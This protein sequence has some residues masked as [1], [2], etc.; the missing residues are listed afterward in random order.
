MN[1]SPSF[2]W[3]VVRVVNKSA[4]PSIDRLDREW[5]NDPR[6]L[7]F[8]SF[9]SSFFQS[10]LCEWPLLVSTIEVNILVF[11]SIRWVVLISTVFLPL[12]ILAPITLVYVFPSFLFS[13]WGSNI[14]LIALTAQGDR[15]LKWVEWWLIPLIGCYSFLCLSSPLIIVI[16]AV[17]LSGWEIGWQRGRS[18]HVPFP[19]SLSTSD[20][21][22]HSHSC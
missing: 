1:V 12:S 11:P 2:H 3:L 5:C 8:F 19:P 4:L 15:E 22:S 17:V 10:F 9:P 21:S 16:T 20:V 6:H 14:S 18:R 7:F 13:Q